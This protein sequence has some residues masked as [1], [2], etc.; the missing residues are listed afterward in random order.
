MWR[1]CRPSYPPT[2]G[3]GWTGRQISTV[4][5]DYSTDQFGT[6]IATDRYF[7]G[8]DFAEPCIHKPNFFAQI[9][10]TTA[11]NPSGV[12]VLNRVSIVH[13]SA[14]RFDDNFFLSIGTCTFGIERAYTVKKGSRVSRLQPGPSLNKLPLGRNNSVMTSLFPPRE[15]LAVTSRL[16]TGNSR[17]F[18]YGVVRKRL[19]WKGF[20]DFTILPSNDHTL[21]SCA[22]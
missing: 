13:T 10:C 3:R 20:H 12:R 14:R 8:Q 15:S 1:P 7:P 21:Y 4:G 2:G 9:C 16:G 17:T 5:R 19:Y 11:F 6:L 22:K 18:F